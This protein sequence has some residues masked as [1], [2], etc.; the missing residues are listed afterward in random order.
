MR[1]VMFVPV[2]VF[3]FSLMYKVDSSPIP[4]YEQPTDL[5]SYRT[6][7]IHPDPHTTASNSRPVKLLWNKQQHCHGVV[8][9][10]SGRHKIQPTPILEPESLVQKESYTVRVAQ[11]FIEMFEGLWNKGRRCDGG[12]CAPTPSKN[13]MQEQALTHP[14]V[15]R[16]AITPGKKTEKTPSKGIL[17]RFWNM[18]YYCGGW[19]CAH[20]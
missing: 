1:V 7:Q 10:L 14:R 6:G 17:R 16:D 4:Y 5:V 19:V 2:T 11:Y 13:S 9:P 12:T 3:V 8:C 18:R 20:P 15:G